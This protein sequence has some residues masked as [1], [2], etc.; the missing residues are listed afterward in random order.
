MMNP[1]QNIQG[2]VTEDAAGAAIGRRSFIGRSLEAGAAIG[3]GACLPARAHASRLDAA[4]P[5]DQGFTVVGIPDTHVDFM[6]TEQRLATISEWIVERARRLNIR[7]VAHLGDAGDRRGS[8][9][10]REMLASCRRGFGPITDAGIA[11]S[12]CIGNHD[13]DRA[14]VGRANGAWNQDEAFGMSLY[15]DAP[16]FGG[17]FEGESADPGPDPGGT[18]NHYFTFDA[19]G[20]KMLMLSLEFGP[21]EKVMRWADHLVRERFADH[22]VMVFTHSYLHTD[23]S[24]VGEGTAYNPKGYADFSTQEGPE[25]THDG[26][27]LWDRYFRHWPHLRMVHSGH[28]IAGPRQAWLAQEGGAGN[29][30]AGLFYNWQEWGYDEEQGEMVRGLP[31]EHGAGMIRLFQV[32]PAEQTVHMANFL[33][34]AGIEAEASVPESVPWG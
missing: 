22:S 30:V 12:V 14:S 10:H 15:E 7:F 2:C 17:T 18:A 28:A 34:S 13:Y 3:L 27:D 24:I 5:A 11:L 8:G 6:C 32:R 9:S 20:V 29:K 4:L 1:N 16:G 21:R 19:A 33:P 26:S 23:G 31:V 25:Y